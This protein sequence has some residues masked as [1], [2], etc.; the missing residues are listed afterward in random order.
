VLL[1]IRLTSFAE[2]SGRENDKV[3]FNLLLRSCLKIKF[4]S[5]AEYPDLILAF[6]GE[7]HT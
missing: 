1:K 2:Y 4:T 7:E 6:A 3:L 5:F